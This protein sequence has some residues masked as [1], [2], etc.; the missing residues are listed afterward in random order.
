MPGLLVGH[1]SRDGR[2]DR[3]ANVPAE[4][5]D[6]VDRLVRA[7]A[8]QLGRPI[9]GQEHQR[10]AGQRRLDDRREEFGGGGAARAGHGDRTA[11]RLR[12]AER[13]E[14]RG[15]LVEMDV[16]VGRAD[17]ARARARAASSATR[18]RPSPVPCR[19]ARG[20]RRPTRRAANARRPRSSA[21]HAI[22]SPSASSAPNTTCSRA[23]PTSTGIS[24]RPAALPD[25]FERPDRDDHRPEREQ[26]PGRE[27]AP[28]VERVDHDAEHDRPERRD[29]ARPIQRARP[30]VAE[31][32]GE[33]A[34]A[35]DGVGGDV[36]EVVRDQD[37][38]GEQADRHRGPPRRRR[39]ASRP[40]RTRSPRSP[41]GRRTRRPSPRPDRARRTASARRCRARARASRARRSARA[42]TSSPRPARARRRRRRG[43]TAARRA[44]PSAPARA[45][46]R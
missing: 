13:E 45:P 23:V 1:V 4:Q 15:A 26:G 32:N 10:R 35:G 39:D 12:D 41:S 38:D 16:H 9:G 19:T 30:R 6:L 43:S 46:R 22:H 37:R 29:H 27:P 20:R 5:P 34:L 8:A 42:T 44:G 33:R 14:A 21:H 31:P 11:G 28:L 7:D 40:G 2:V 3:R 17:D 36:A 18:A 25:L 24:S